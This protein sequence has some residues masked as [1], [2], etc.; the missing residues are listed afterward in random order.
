MGG[1]IAVVA[2]RISWEER[3]LIKALEELGLQ[4]EWVND[5]SLCLGPQNSGGLSG[6]DLVVVRSRSYTRGGL[7]AAMTAT[8]GIPTVNSAPAIQACENKLAL[9]CLLQ[10]AGMPVPDFRLVVSR[11]D[12]KTAIAQMPLPLVLKPT[13]GGMGR[14]VHLIRETDTAQS[15]YDYIEDLGHAFEQACLVE[16]YQGDRSVR[17]FVVGRRMVAA[18][19][20]VSDGD[21]WRN[22]A[23]VGSRQRPIRHEP[24]LELIAEEVA[25]LLGDGVYGIDL[26]A[27]SAGYVIN[28]VNHAPGFRAVAKATGVDIPARIGRLVQE[29]L[30]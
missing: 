13:F 30:R 3:Q 20:F 9:R 18:A 12:F 28:E 2:D 1:R 27:T 24:E 19:E 21:E 23:A 15:L 4:A 8:A 26:F 17:C 5:E 29:I 25:G 10:Q 11:D 14:R 16:P 22:N 7:L 6:Y